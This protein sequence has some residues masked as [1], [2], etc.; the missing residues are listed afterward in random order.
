MLIFTSNHGGYETKYRQPIIRR[1]DYMPDIH[2]FSDEF[3]RWHFRHR[4]E[5]WGRVSSA[6][7]SGGPVFKAVTCAPQLHTRSRQASIV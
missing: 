4:G 5:P 7:R 6:E 2:F 1:V 3:L